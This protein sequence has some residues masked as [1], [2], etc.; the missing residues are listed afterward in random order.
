MIRRCK[1]LVW[2]KR[3]WLEV[4][5]MA[6]L[7]LSL[8]T[9]VLVY[10]TEVECESKL[11]AE[12]EDLAREDEALSTQGD[13]WKECEADLADATTKLD[14]VQKRLAAELEKAGLPSEKI[15]QLEGSLLKGG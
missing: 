6:V 5:L 8:F 7:L 11:V 2:A 14:E 13:R 9:D 3:T 12:E 10:E 1:N 4:V 15:K